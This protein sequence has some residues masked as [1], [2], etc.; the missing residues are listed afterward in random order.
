M[1]QSYRCGDYRVVI[2]AAVILP[3]AVLIGGTLP[4][5]CQFCVVQQNPIP[6][7]VG[8]LYALNTFGSALG[9]MICGMVLIPTV[10]VNK[11]IFFAAVFNISAGVIVL[12]L[13]KSNV[14]QREDKKTSGENSEFHPSLK[15]PL[16]TFLDKKN[17]IILYGAIFFTGFAALGNEILWTRFL[18]LI[19]HN[20]VYTYMITISVLLLGISFGSA[21]ISSFDRQLKNNSLYFGLAQML[22]G[23]TIT[24]ALFLP[25]AAW[26]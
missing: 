25:P 20:T 6:G 8:F 12:L 3:S 24:M 2:C 18:S 17:S 9:C 11:S 14:I 5:F 7:S 10:G 19:I 13:G 23:I 1:V 15:P 26:N 16:K 4:V 21:L 22:T